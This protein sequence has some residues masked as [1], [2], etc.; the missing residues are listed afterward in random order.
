[1]Q[2]KGKY[3]K[4]SPWYK[5]YLQ[6]G[7]W[8]PFCSW[9]DELLQNIWQVMKTL[10][11]PTHIQQHT[12]YVEQI[13]HLIWMWSQPCGSQAHELAS[14]RLKL[15]CLF[16]KTVNKLLTHSLSLISHTVP[17]KS[18]SIEWER[19]YN[20]LLVQQ[21]VLLQHARLCCLKNGLYTLHKMIPQCDIVFSEGNYG[22]RVKSH[23]QEGVLEQIFKHGWIYGV[24][25]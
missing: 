4:G 3:F 17:V 7:W 10:C 16:S 2:K 23:S 6:R 12:V 5:Y 8:M 22:G 21:S 25:R 11:S 20:I 15:S 19:V 18:H 9:D 24:T 13:I 14:S 1:M